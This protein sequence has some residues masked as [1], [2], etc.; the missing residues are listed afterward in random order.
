MERSRW[1]RPCRLV[2][3]LVM[4][5]VL[6]SF[7]GA[8]A[9]SDSK[10]KGMTPQLV[11]DADY[12]ESLVA[13]YT[14][15]MNDVLAKI[16]TQQGNGNLQSQGEMDVD[17]KTTAAAAKRSSRSSPTTVTK[18]GQTPDKASGIMSILTEYDVDAPLQNEILS[19]SRAMTPR[20]HIIAHVQTH[21]PDMHVTTAHDIITAVHVT[22]DRSQPQQQD[23][24]KDNAL[25]DIKKANNYKK[26][27]RA[28]EALKRGK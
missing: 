23:F 20:E 27:V 10:V 24:V 21:Y 6:C 7:L 14:A 17:F 15:E 12:V 11:S 26:Q 1:P 3:A 8:L 16:K 2:L 18:V 22:A 5:L 19:M 28:R 13:N 4:C 9:A 25:K